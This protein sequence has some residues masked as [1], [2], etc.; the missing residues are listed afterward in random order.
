MAQSAQSAPPNILWIGVD[1]MRQDTAGCYGNEICRTPHIDRLAAEG[2][3]F[4]RA[5]TT[6]PLCTPARASMFTGK[7]AFHHGMGTNCDMYHSLAAELPDPNLLLHRLLLERGY[8]C[9][10]AGKW[11][12]GT[13]LGPGDYGFEGLSLPGYGDL[14]KTQAYKDYLR[15][16][17]WSPGPVADAVYGNGAEHTLLAGKWNGPPESSPVHFLTEYTLDL[18]DRLAGSGRPFFLTCQF[19]G[20]HPPY[21][22]ADGFYGMHD[23]SAIEPWINFRDDYRGKPESVRRFRPNFYRTLPDR[24]EEWRELVGRYYDYTAMIDAQ[25]G[26]LIARLEQLGIAGDTLIVLTSDHGDMNGS[27][28]GLFDK[29]FLY[30]EAMRIPLIVKAPRRAG[31]SGGRRNGSLVS[32]MDIFPT[33]LELAGIPAPD[34]DGRSLLPCLNGGDLRREALYL[35]FHGLRY[36]YS[37]RA[38]VTRDGY[39]YIFTPGDRDEVYDLQADPGELDNLA[40]DGGRIGKTGELRELLIACAHETGDPL[41]DYVSKCFGRWDAVS[42]QVDASNASYNAPQETPAREGGR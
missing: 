7:Y 28:G 40:E 17:G 4:D 24:W 3:V 16:H 22:P 8:R 42:S 21:M 19:W 39:K 2:T 11:H 29:G 27:H 15:R 25:I 26:R 37:Q 1:Q 14:K 10:Y 33:I 9:G 34:T 41:R 36:L 38:L 13:K 30:E 20:P 12:V 5:Y 35:E 18:M 31:M 32:H 6:C 23:R